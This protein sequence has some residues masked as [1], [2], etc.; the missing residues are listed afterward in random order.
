MASASTRRAGDRTRIKL[1]QKRKP[2]VTRR[3]AE[4]RTLNVEAREEMIG[5][6]WGTWG[7]KDTAA[8]PR[9]QAT[10]LGL[11][12]LWGCKGVI[13]TESQGPAPR[14]DT[15]QTPRLLLQMLHVIIIA[16]GLLREAS[17]W[18]AMPA[19]T[20]FAQAHQRKK[21]NSTEVTGARS[22]EQ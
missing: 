22:Q 8:K 10:T 16:G 9:L 21:Q 12:G 18:P 11:R 5:R 14:G 7:L 17:M 4:G 13:Q 6:W 1:K 15:Y 2:N 20:E 3:F 19:T